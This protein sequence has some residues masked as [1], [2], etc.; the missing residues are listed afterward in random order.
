MATKSFWKTLTKSGNTQAT[1]SG[2]GGRA[3]KTTFITSVKS[4]ST[5]ITKSMTSSGTRTTIRTTSRSGSTLLGTVS[6]F[7]SG[8]KRR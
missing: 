8:I 7:F 5:R 6:T 2:G 1:R 4:G 3:T